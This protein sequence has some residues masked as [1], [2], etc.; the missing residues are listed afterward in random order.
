MAIFDVWLHQQGPFPYDD[1]NT[2]PDGTPY[3]ALYTDGVIR[4]GGIY[5]GEYVLG[6]SEV[7]TEQKMKRLFAL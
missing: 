4:V 1:D 5:M 3:S 2:Y 6:F 7:M